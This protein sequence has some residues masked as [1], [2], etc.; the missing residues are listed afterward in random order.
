MWRPVVKGEASARPRFQPFGL[1]SCLSAS[2]SASLS[3]FLSPPPSV[4]REQCKVSRLSFLQCETYTKQAQQL[5]CGRWPPRVHKQLDH[6]RRASGQTSVGFCSLACFAQPV[7]RRVAGFPFV[8]G[9]RFV[10]LLC[11]ELA[12]GGVALPVR[13][14][15]LEILIAPTFAHARG[16]L[17]WTLTCQTYG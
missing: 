8:Y 16:W 5:Q 15:C 14:L 17:F 6:W 9:S 7:S 3:P 11:T 10:C 2:F 12:S 13:P 1:S 4:Y